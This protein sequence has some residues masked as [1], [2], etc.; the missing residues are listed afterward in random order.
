M[1]VS[2]VVGREVAYATAQG[3]RRSHRI[4][5]INA[6]DYPEHLDGIDPD[7]VSDNLLVRASF[8]AG[9]PSTQSRRSSSALPEGMSAPCNTYSMSVWPMPSSEAIRCADRWGRPR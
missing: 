3:A 5:Y 8:M 9:E 7:H 1:D 6:A 4:A 2:A